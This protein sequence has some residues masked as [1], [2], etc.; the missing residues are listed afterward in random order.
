MAVD[1]RCCLAANPPCNPNKTYYFSAWA[2]S[3]NSVTPFANLQF[4]VNGVPVG[5]TAPLP[6]RVENNNPPYNWIRF[7]G[8]WPSGSATSAIIQ[9]VDLQTALGGNDFGLDDISFGTLAAPPAIINPGIVGGNSAQ[10][11]GSTFRLTTNVTGGTRPFSYLWTFP[12]GSTIT[13]SIVT[14]TNATLSNSGRYRVAITENNGCD[15]D[16]ASTTVSIIAKPAVS[17]SG[18]SGICVNGATALSPTSGG[19]WESNNPP[20][21]TVTNG[22][23]VTGLSAGS[24]TFTF[25]QTSTGCSNTTSAV[26][27]NALPTISIETPATCDPSLLTYSIAVTVSSGSVTS[28]SGTV[29][30]T[31]G[32]HWSIT[33]V[34]VGTNIS[35]TATGSNSCASTLNITSPNCNCPVIT[36]P[37]SGGNQQYCQGETIPS[38]SVTVLSGET[39][40]WYANP[41]NGTPLLTG[42]SSY[43]PTSAGT[44]YAESRNTLSN[45]TSTTR[46]AVSITMNPAPTITTAASA[47]NICFSSDSQTTPLSYTA[48]TGS[49]ST[50]SIT[51]NSS[52]AN[53][54]SAVTNVSL[55]E[56]PV[57]IDIP[58]N[59]AAGTYT[60]TITVSDSKGCVSTDRTFTVTVN[61][62]PTITTEVSATKVC[63]SPGTQTTSLTYSSTTELPTT[64]SITWDTSPTNSFAEITNA[65]LPESPIAITVPAGT[66]PG[67]YSGTITVKNA[68]GCVGNGTI[69]TVTINPLPTIS[70]TGIPTICAN[71]TTMLSPS[72]GGSWVSNS[73]TVASVT[74]SGVV[75]GLSAGSSTF[76]FTN[77]LTGCSSTTS[78]ITVNPLPVITS[79]PSDELDCEGH[80]VSFNVVATGSGLSYTWQRKKPSGSFADIPI[81]TN[82]SY[83]SPGTIRLQNV[84]NSDAPDGTQYRVVIT[85]SDTCSTTSAAATLTVNEITGITPVATSV[86][87]CQGSNYSYLVTTS[88]PS[89]VV[90]YQW[91]KYDSP[92][93]WFPVIDGGAISGATTDH[94]VFTGATPSES[95]QY[96]VT[97]VFHSSGSDCNVTSDSRNR[98]LTV[99]P[100]PSC[101]ISGDLSV[102]A[103]STNNLYS[104]TPTPSDNVTHSWNISGNGTIVGSATGSTVSVNAT[105]AG[106][107]TL[108][109]N[110]SRLGCTSSCSYDVT[111]VIPCSISPVIDAVPNGTSTTYTAP[112]GMDTYNWSITGNGSITSATNLQTVTVLAGNSCTDYTLTLA[113]TVR[114]S[115]TNCSQTVN[116][117]DNQRPIF[118]PPAAISECVESLFVATYNGANMDI[119]PN[120]PDYFTLEAGNALLDLTGLSDNC[121]TLTSLQINWRIDFSGGTPASI[122]GTGQPSAYGVPIQFPGD[123]T[124]FLDLTHTITYWV[125]DCNGNI[126]STQTTTITIKPRPN[127]IK[128]N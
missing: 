21:A 78:A 24:A 25:T 13:D 71:S 48:T 120:R 91:K 69:F 104:S 20:I 11:E 65:D 98:T 125:T 23:L 96:K 61:P 87:I 17:I 4:N 102:F 76:T 16:T 34:N 90:S 107:F 29:N 5:T 128:T 52:P 42:D 8:T 101:I 109:D 75:T 18:T 66:A 124:T 122:T 30:N 58:A 116:I 80:I 85:N 111:V 115:G 22:G 1:R 3:L 41:T 89:N 36:A 39:V 53:S 84:G 99:N 86:T 60:G 14:V 19:T 119:N 82:V 88:Y 74:N 79:Q 27:V 2:I 37:T 50:Y 64:Y 38:L 113:L 127:I 97:I 44:Y 106:T 7:Y 123:G 32:N 62:L 105:G 51:W 12:D 28:S 117:T 31:S 63:F 46:T 121:C 92:G 72:T 9:I 35:L 55:P 6:A 54:F 49:P 118:T 110:I 95:G 108:T 67:T 112:V 126:S 57:N 68:I 83:P 93:L 77:T 43:T 10:C 94:L 45:C 70:I 40:D 33:N 73:P 103:G 81:E 100:T 59:T 56:S 26:T 15:A 114:G 47:A